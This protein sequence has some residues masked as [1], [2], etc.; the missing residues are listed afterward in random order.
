MK[1]ILTFSERTAFLE[2]RKKW[3]FRYREGLT[4]RRKNI[5]LRVGSAIHYGFDQWM[6]AKSDNEIREGFFKLL[7]EGFKD[8]D[9]TPEFKDD[10]NFW[11]RL[12]TVARDEFKSKV[13][14]I[15]VCTE[16]EFCI[17]IPHRRM[18]YAGKIDAIIEMDGNRWMVE[19]K[20]KAAI[21]ETDLFEMQVDEQITG[22]MWALSKMEKDIPVGC[23]YNVIRKPNAKVK[24]KE[25]WLDKQ[26]A[27][28][29][30]TLQEIVF[31]NE[32][33]IADFELMLTNF[34]PDI[35]DPAICRRISMECGWKCSYKSLCI[36]D[37]EAA[38]S[39]YEIRRPHSEL[40][41]DVTK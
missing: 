32:K 33:E 35:R 36:E 7:S 30:I 11:W 40:S 27:A 14:C 37:T 41:E 28:G 4:L 16:Q 18:S 10:S 5:K 34:V 38:R 24:F 39:V 2:C 1:D 8:E 29:G 31:R 6:Q 15:P 22:Y 19:H 9:W 26:I 17:P 13:Q 3:F 20:T 25:K 12:F 21:K 23:I